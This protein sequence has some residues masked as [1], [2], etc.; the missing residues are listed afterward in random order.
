METFKKIKNIDQLN[1]ILPEKI[2]INKPIYLKGLELNR[3]F[4]EN[5]SST[6]E[7]NIVDIG[8][9]KV[10]D[11]LKLNLCLC[12]V[13]LI[14]EED[15][16]KDDYI[17]IE[18]DYDL[19]NRLFSNPILYDLIDIIIPN[20]YVELLEWAGNDKVKGIISSKEF[21]IYPD[22][23]EEIIEPLI[24]FF[25]KKYPILEE[26]FFIENT[27][28]NVEDS[29]VSTNLFSLISENIGEDINKTS[30]DAE[31]LL[32]KHD[33]FIELLNTDNLTE[34]YYDFNNKDLEK[35]YYNLSHLEQKLKIKEF[36]YEFDNYKINYSKKNQL[37]TKFIR[38]VED[39]FNEVEYLKVLITEM[40]Q[41]ATHYVIEIYRGIP[42]NLSNFI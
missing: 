10:D 41:L 7:Y 39:E 2:Q 27:E 15:I 24:D 37:L 20:D 12:N 31:K 36:N 34:I 17:Y 8:F 28:I 38:D 22:P 29:Y 3:W 18:L 5:H 16:G 35:I 14:D 11:Q 23:I 40:N 1:S 33:W 32:S 21:V 19:E 9:Y 30:D 42:I 6:H 26:K 25:H 4:R 13:I